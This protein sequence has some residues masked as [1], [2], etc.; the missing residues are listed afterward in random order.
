MNA[1]RVGRKDERTA[2]SY[3]QS[4]RL[5]RDKD[6]QVRAELALRHDL[7]P[8]ILYFLA[9]DPSAEVRRCIAENPETPVKANLLLIKDRDEAVRQSLAEKISRLTPNLSTEER[10]QTQRYV[11]QAL[12]TLAKDQATRVRQ[13]LANALKDVAHAPPSV[14]QR[15]AR[16]AEELVAT[17]VLEF[18]PL[19]SDQDLIEI[20]EAG[21]ASGNLKAISRRKGLGPTVADAIVS[22]DDESA[23]AALLENKSAQIREQTLDD[24][25]E[26]AALITIWHKGLVERPRISSKA[27]QKLAT[28][29]AA[30]L[31]DKLQARQDL[32]TETARRVAQEVHRRL[33]EGQNPD[34]VGGDAMDDTEVGSTAGHD[35]ESE[36]MSQALADGDRGLVQSGLA[37]RCGFRE[38][39]V[40]KILGSGSPKAI[41]ALAWKAGLSMRFA[42]QLQVQLG[43]ITPQNVLNAQNGTDF[44]L[45]TEQMEWQ[46]DF[47]GSLQL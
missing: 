13:I 23:I 1:G 6:P 2:M 4:K 45:S 16:D 24:L 34:A 36:A 17:P 32:D 25:V 29:V 35:A 3:D 30:A 21:C 47:F 44:P 14:I 11:V 26:R 9:A 12:E 31:L 5:V 22:T 40:E 33:V 15:L 37:L 7:K 27:A 8:E 46:L 10:E 28:F 39:V 41:T 18:S 19:L 43:G 42:M 38:N 20:I